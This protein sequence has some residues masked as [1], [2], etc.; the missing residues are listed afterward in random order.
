MNIKESNQNQRI[1]IESSCAITQLKMLSHLRWKKEQDNK[2]SIMLY[3]A[4]RKKDLFF[5]HIRDPVLSLKRIHSRYLLFLGGNFRSPLVNLNGYTVRQINNFTSQIVQTYVFPATYKEL[6]DRTILVTSSLLS[7][8]K[9]KSKRLVYPSSDFLINNK[10]YTRWKV[11]VKYS[12]MLCDPD[13]E[14][15]SLVI[16][17]S[18]YG[19]DVKRNINYYFRPYNNG[20]EQME[21]FW[22]KYMNEVHNN[23]ISAVYKHLNKYKVN[24]LV[25]PV[26]GSK[27]NL[28]SRP[29]EKPYLF[30]GNNYDLY[31]FGRNGTSSKI[32]KL[33][34][35]N[36]KQSEREE[37]WKKVYMPYYAYPAKRKTGFKCAPH[38]VLEKGPCSINNSYFPKRIPLRDEETLLI[39][40][41][42]ASEA[43]VRE[44]ARKFSTF[45]DITSKR[46]KSAKFEGLVKSGNKD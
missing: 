18:N 37:H 38:L 23:V 12:I 2:E 6:T 9:V 26:R 20:F 13:G 28:L 14:P 46:P 32:K 31:S 42:K 35:E 44:I 33:A 16:S 10:E 34:F 11:D 45:T 21:V 40:K 41:Y 30:C 22:N 19:R 25:D 15:I 29:D 43:D 3:L 39:R 17:R 4:S 8:E 36:L 7:N 24:N 27:H 1:E 5:Y